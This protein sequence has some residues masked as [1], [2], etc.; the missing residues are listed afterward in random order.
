MQPGVFRA[1]R[2]LAFG[3]RRSVA[4]V[5]DLVEDT[6]ARQLVGADFLQDAVGDLEL[7]LEAGIAGVDDVQ[8]QAGVQRFV[9]G[10]LERG[11]QAVR[12]VLDEADGVADQ[13]ARHALG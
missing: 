8:Q 2:G 11:H 5:V 1:Q 7:A 12:Q 9:Q 4:D 10:G 13:H 3:L 6:D